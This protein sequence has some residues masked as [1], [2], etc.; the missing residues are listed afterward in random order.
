MPVR[1]EMIEWSQ[2]HVHTTHDTKY[3][4]AQQYLY[5]NQDTNTLRV[6]RTTSGH[7][8]NWMST[9]TLT[10]CVRHEITVSTATMVWRVGHLRTAC[11]NEYQ[12]A[13][14]WHAYK[15][16]HTL[17][18]TRDISEHSDHSVGRTKKT[19]GLCA[20]WNT[21]EHN[22]DCMCTRT[23]TVCVRYEIPI[24]TTTIA[25]VQEHLLA[26]R[27]TKYHWALQWLQGTRKLT[28]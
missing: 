19:H 15:G 13:Q 17:C 2:V 21:S 24:S 8:N 9:R 11:D 10:I 3:L 6:R 26:A 12:W 5:A 28:F 1:T 25:C 18:V 7:S 20:T 16:T 14:R 27:D 23:L 4:W 22:N